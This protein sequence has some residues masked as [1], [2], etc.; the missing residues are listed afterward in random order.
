[1]GVPLSL[2]SLKRIPLI[3]SR[4]A[5]NGVKQ[6]HKEEFS[7]DE[8]SLQ[9]FAR[10][11]NARYSLLKE[12]NFDLMI[13]LILNLLKFDCNFPGDSGLSLILFSV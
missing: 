10:G 9:D 5:K 13:Y 1:M 7:S 8:R 2:V 3:Y 4:T 11:R 6:N 12:H